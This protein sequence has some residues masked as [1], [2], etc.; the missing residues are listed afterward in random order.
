MNEECGF[1]N[2]NHLFVENLI[3]LNG[4]PR[5]SIGSSFPLYLRQGG[6]INVDIDRI[7][8]RTLILRS[9]KKIK[10][11]DIIDENINLISSNDKN[12]HFHLS[13]IEGRQIFIIAKYFKDN[14]V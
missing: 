9:S 7:S 12:V 8:G 1:E 2:E 14:I 11:E 4:N 13:K 6:E 3:G 10:Q 5:F